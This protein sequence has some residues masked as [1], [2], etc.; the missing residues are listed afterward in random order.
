MNKI[1]ASILLLFTLFST[2]Q[3][4]GQEYLDDLKDLLEEASGA[5]KI[6]LLNQITNRCLDRSN[7]YNCLKFAKRAANLADEI[8]SKKNSSISPDEF[9]LAPES[10]FLLGK[11]YKVRG[12]FGAAARA[13]ETA[14]V[15]ANY[16]TLSEW[17]LK[18]E[19]ELDNARFLSGSAKQKI[20]K[21]KASGLFKD[22]G[23]G[24]DKT[25]D[26]LA[27]AAMM[28]IAKSYEKKQKY[29]KALEEY[30]KVLVI[31]SNNG[32]NDK[33]EEI[34]EKIN[35]LSLEFSKQ[36]TQEAME[37]ASAITNEIEE[38]FSEIENAVV[39]DIKIEVPEVEESE[40]AS[41]SETVVINVPDP[42]ISTPMPVPETKV[43]S[44]NKIVQKTLSKEQ[45]EVQGMKNKAAQAAQ[46]RDYEK[47]IQYYKEYAELEA[48]L[49]EDQRMQ[50]LALLEQAHELETREKE[51]ELLKTKEENSQLQLEQNKIELERQE[52]NRKTLLGGLGFLLLTLLG[53]GYLYQINKKEHKKLGVAYTDLEQAQVKL[54]DAEQKIKSLLNQQV[55]GEVADALL[56]GA[57]A[58]QVAEKFVCVMFLDIRNFTPF[59]EKLKAEEIIEY[60]NNVLG[61]M[62]ESIINHKGIVNQIMGDGFMATFG[63]PVSSGNDCLQAYNAAREIMKEVEK[64]SKNGTIPPT[65]IGIGLHAGKVVTGNVG[66]KDRKQYSVT[67][68][69]VITAARLEQLNKKYKSTLI[70]SKEVIDH[71]PAELTSDLSFDKVEVKGRSQPVEAAII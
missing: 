3:L 25:G 2:Q 14:L 55:S 16:F 57:T 1:L 6:T 4:H 29:D 9:Y 45:K 10:F 50:A 18:I 66:T 24:I 12:E 71:L 56:A 17:Q 27:V 22:I 39:P 21:S 40:I 38:S 42:V 54:K 47:S 43:P 59:V 64:R 20:K 31:H 61:L 62:I 65:K 34:T 49:A 36:A 67:G 60:T 44:I 26:A 51:L 52:R 5:E 35:D 37:R 15:K 53:L 13:F 32:D 11:A 69:P 70:V 46:S 7:N 28:R 33:I 8:I 58:N 23:K 41:H 19:P 48:K 63:A 30:G 68:N